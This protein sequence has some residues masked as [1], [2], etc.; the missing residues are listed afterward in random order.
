MKLDTVKDI[1]RQHLI[2]N[3]YDA[4]LSDGCECSC[5]DNELLV[6]CCEDC[7]SC[8]PAY[9]TLDDYTYTDKV[10]RD[11]HNLYSF[12]VFFDNFSMYA[13][14]EFAYSAFIKHHNCDK[15]AVFD[16]NDNLLHCFDAHDWMNEFLKETRKSCEELRL[17][18]PAVFD[19]KAHRYVI[20]PYV[21]V[22]MECENGK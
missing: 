13:D 6:C 7:K 12:S 22:D 4:L 9:R 11:R 8:R 3:G 21:P 20:K 15:I 1:V 10:L 19:N 2:D 5:S 16:S 14:D 17:I 18:A